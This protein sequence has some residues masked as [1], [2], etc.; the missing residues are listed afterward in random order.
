MESLFGAHRLFDGGTIHRC[1]ETGVASAASVDSAISG[2]R[3]RCGA[4]PEIDSDRL[5]T[6][7]ADLS[8]WP[9]RVEV[10]SEGQGAPRSLQNDLP[11]T[12]RRSGESPGLVT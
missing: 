2:P 7:T 9:P 12:R 5:A 8:Q 1:S 10:A 11:W 3:E 4:S 6:V